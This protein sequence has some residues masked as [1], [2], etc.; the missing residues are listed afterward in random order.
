M[1][2]R[3]NALR[4]TLATNR[5]P[6][7]ATAL[8]D[9]GLNVIRAENTSGKSALINGMLYALGIEILVGKRGIEGTKP[10][11]WKTGEYEGQEFNV[12][13]SFVDI[14]ISNSLGEL[15]TVRRYVAGAKN[16]RLIEV[17][18]GPGITGP[19]GS[20]HRVESF[21]VGLE[22]A[23]QRERGFHYFLADFLKLELPNVKRFKG[24]DV[25]LYVECVAPLMFIEQIRGW[26]G[27]Q[28]TL[29]QSFGIRN[30]AKLSVEY[31]L[32]LDVIE[33]EKRRMQ[34]SEEANRIREDWGFARD[35]ML[36]I[37]SQVGGRLMNVPDRPVSLLTEEP[38]ISVSTDGKDDTPLDD[39]LVV[40]RS[41]LLER[42]GDE[43]Y[44]VAGS[45]DLEAKLES[46]EKSLLV[47]Q[48][49]VTQ[50]RYDI[51]SEEE[52][53]C[54]LQNRLE[55]I[56]N[57]IQRNKD[58]RRL[59]DFGVETELSI[60]QDKCPT[61]NQSIQDSLIP[62]ECEVMSV[63][64]NI[65][66]LKSEAEA[67]EMI[68]S[69]GKERL[70][71]LQ[72]LK[73]GKSKVVT[74]LR[75]TIRDLRSDLLKTQDVS[76]AEIREQI[77]LQE[78]ITRLEELR[79]GFEEQTN[80]L[81]L[82]AKLWGENRARHSDLPDDYFSEG[83]KAKLEAVSRCF[84]RNVH[85]FGYRSTGVSQLHISQDNYR[86]V[87]DEFE[88]AFGASASDNIRLI[89]AY[90]LALLQVSSSH[91]GN[92]WG[93][94]VFDE[95]EQQKMKEASSDALYAEIAKINRDECQVIIATSAS[96]EMTEKRLENLPHKLLEF[97]DIV[98]RRIQ[99]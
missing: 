78:E 55:F 65:N 22:G 80:R 66:F 40:K 84:A 71:R 86:P 77:H 42:S 20:Q 17:V 54:K 2:L 11:L 89:W 99:D 90:T 69:A 25:P 73:A 35:L 26:S 5:G 68:I 36:Q 45:E 74:N 15:I 67:V 57:D 97:G 92:H 44:E 32:S 28:A 33:N 79:D 1:K 70:S 39:L 34:I 59:R 18:F 96:V 49:E 58:I 61:C 23:A 50:L 41:L 93:I 56:K 53:S 82:A 76:I 83:D 3:I 75:S 47:V 27:I 7:G 43:T 63:K 37:A 48:A 4:V 52:E 46:Q 12:V 85:N 9:N 72:G 94:L 29:P 6:F 38:W 98:I 95:P 24:D 31:I 8:F 81:K 62:T 10:V 87:C 91:D 51:R 14:E 16:S 64:D 21:F 13:E 88:V 30:V 19:Q 60:I